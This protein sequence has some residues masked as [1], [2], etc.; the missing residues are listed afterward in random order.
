M[1]THLLETENERRTS[2]LVSKQRDLTL[3]IP[4]DSEFPTNKICT[5]K[6]T[7]LNFIPKSIFQQFKKL[8]NIYFLLISILQSIP[9]ISVSEGIPNLLLPLFIVTFFS[10]F[11]DLLEDIKRKQSDKDE[12]N[13]KTFKRLNRDWVKSTWADICVGDIVKINQNEYFPADLILIS[14]SDPKGICYIETKNL[15][16]E[17]NLKHKLANKETQ[18]FFEFEA[19]LDEIHAKIKCPDANPLIFH[20]EGIFRMGKKCIPLTYKQFLLRGSCLKNT[21]WVV[22]LVI[23]TGHETKI[24][25]NSPK[26]RQKSSKVE[27]QMNSEILNIFLLQVTL[28]IFAAIYYTLWF[29]TC[30]DQSYLELKYASTPLSIIFFSSFFTWM[31]LLTNFVPISLLVTLEMV[32]YIQA[33]LISNDLLLYCEE[34]D[35]AAV[36][37]S[38]NLNE[39]LGQVT[40]IFSDK[41]GTLTCNIMEFRKMSIA[42][43]TFGTDSR[44]QEKVQGVD[45]VDPE[46]D[47]CTPEAKEFLLHLATCHTIISQ[48]SDKGVEYNSSSPDELALVNAAKY[49]G[50]E[51][52]NREDNAIAISV[53]GKILTIKILEIIEFTSD[54][55]RMTIVA[56]MPDNKIK[57]LCKGAD[58]IL[59]PRLIN[60]NIMNNTWQHL[61]KYATEGL[62]TLIIGYKEI[63]DSE[64]KAWK[65]LYDDAHLDLRLKD[66]KMAELEDQLENS[67]ILLGATAIE[68]KL[69]PN[70]PNTIEFIK[71]IGIKLWVLTGDKIET[72]INISFSCGLL[73]DEVIRIPIQSHKTNQIK[74]EMLKA[75]ETL[76]LDSMK[77]ALVISGEALAKINKPEMTEDLLKIAEKCE[78]V[79]ACRVSPQQKAQIVK[80]IKNGCAN[81]RTLSIGDGANDVNMICEAHIGVG[82][83]GVEGQQAVRASDY[84]IGQFSFIKRLLCVHGRECNRRNST[85]ICFN[86]YKNVLITIPLFFYGVFSAYSGQELYNMWSYQFFNIFFAAHPICLYAVL[87]RENK[88]EKLETN[89]ELYQKSMKGLFFNSKV[90]WT[91]VLEA[92]LQGFLILSVCLFAICQV[93]G[94]KNSGKMDNMWVASEVI[95]GVIVITVNL[96]VVLLCH[97]QFSVIILASLLCSLSYFVFAWVLTEVAS[98]SM[99][100]DNFDS[101]GST[102]RMMI[103]PNTYLAAGLVIVSNFLLQPVIEKVAGGESRKVRVVTETSEDEKITNRKTLEEFYV[104]HMGFAFSGEAGHVPQLLNPELFT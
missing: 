29:S 83:A 35:I 102:Y 104:P 70:V 39:E 88:L 47:P 99:L 56:K 48:R 87:D 23:Y 64:F 45:F 59:R 76:T 101:R 41:T 17:T 14:S 36:V 43:R 96:K 32:R 78:V 18:I 9:S 8:A 75:L 58:S 54:R 85:L 38:S 73:T 62:R 91:W 24:M 31:L 100:L 4:L 57:V 44:M 63:K 52:L 53:Q 74:Q 33:F 27:K 26:A 16:G 34:N 1:N 98:I 28:C 86:F 30:K 12:N 10:A 80:L 67:F 92:S 81:S 68:D 51:F 13:C 103:N 95:F 72:A 77:F 89:P 69:Q 2:A 84:A 55:K 97:V 66:Q 22:G 5:S 71:Q 20:F 60:S 25:L 46:F 6:Y 7:C 93:T 11:K 19:R 15:D 65:S 90:F 40:H 42:G 94:N 49:F 82:I 79:L 50:V 37:Q 3:P 21:E 61:E